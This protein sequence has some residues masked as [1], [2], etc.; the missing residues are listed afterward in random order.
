MQEEDTKEVDDER[1]ESIMEVE[2]NPILKWVIL[3]HMFYSKYVCI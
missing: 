3:L 1:I 2:C